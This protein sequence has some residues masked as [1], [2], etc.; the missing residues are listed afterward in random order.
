MPRRKSWTVLFYIIAKS[1]DTE[2][3]KGNAEYINSKADEVVKRIKR[4]ARNF[5]DDMYVAYQVVFD[6]HEGRHENWFTELLNADDDKPTTHKG[7]FKNPGSGPSDSLTG[8]LLGF[9][10]WALPRCPADHTA[11]FFWGHS[12]GPAG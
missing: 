12:A 9:Y 11:T 6:T 1:L 3:K 7:E 4:A 5:S 8:D 10:A 2:D